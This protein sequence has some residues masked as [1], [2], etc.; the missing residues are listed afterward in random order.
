MLVS[1][2]SIGS[3]NRTGLQWPE[4]CSCRGCHS[5]G[6]CLSWRGLLTSF[7]L[8]IVA[9]ITAMFTDASLVFVT[10][11]LHCPIE[12]HWPQGTTKFKTN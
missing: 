6:R 8:L 7:P 9:V 1:Y 5:A 4:V 11:E 2:M 12:N 3:S 10:T